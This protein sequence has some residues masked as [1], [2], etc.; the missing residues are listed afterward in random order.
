MQKGLAPILIVLLIAL[1]IGGYFIYSN[2]SNHRSQTIQPSPRSID[3]T[4]NWKTYT[5]KNEPF[6]FKYPN[7]WVLREDPP[8]ADMKT[9]V[10]QTGPFDDN[11]QSVL[12][13]VINN[14]NNLSIEDYVKEGLTDSSLFTFTFTD[15]I[16]GGFHGK[17]TPLVSGG[18]HDDEGAFVKKENKIYEIRW[19]GWRGKNINSPDIY[20]QILSTFKFTQ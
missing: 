20:N 18:T 6:T 10:V 19:P 7:N 1:G 17:H 9:V 2:E 14:P 13:S 5:S 15:I 12:V 4:M 16:I 3:E 8:N 11:Y